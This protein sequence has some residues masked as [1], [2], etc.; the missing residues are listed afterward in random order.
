M[1][2]NHRD[3]F[4]QGAAVRNTDPRLGKSLQVIA[5]TPVFHVST[6]GV[7]L[8]A[9]IN[10][11][12]V[13]IGI[14]G[15]VAWDVTGASSVNVT[16]NTCTLD[17]ADVTNPT[18]SVTASITYLGELYEDTKVIAKVFDGL[19]GSNGT[20]TAVLDLYKWSATTPTTFPSGSSTYT[21][22]T[23]Q[24]TMPGT[25]NGWTATPGA[26]VPGQTIWIARQIKTDATT[27]LTTSVPWTVAT[28]MSIA[29]AGADGLNGYRGA[30]LELYKWAAAQPTA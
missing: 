9:S 5:D 6:G 11:S 17:F 10:L 19:V 28:A 29:A 12:A 25:P 4:L 27:D 30:F 18:A 7:G 16:G 21:W 2:R 22:A 26:V 24:F 23:A 15:T 20:R 3:A 14:T 8:P 1:V 13:L